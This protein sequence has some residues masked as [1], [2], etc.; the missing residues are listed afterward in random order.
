MIGGTSQASA[1]A[2][3][4]PCP[5]VQSAK[6]ANQCLGDP[7]G[8]AIDRNRQYRYHGLISEIGVTSK[9]T[10]IAIM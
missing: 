1:L 6:I 3:N 9:N 2:A 5:A 7:R 8:N 10:H 4:L